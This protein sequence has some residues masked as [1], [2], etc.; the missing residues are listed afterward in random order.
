M[1]FFN[2]CN[3]FDHAKGYGIPDAFFDL[4][5]TGFQATQATQRFP[6]ALYRQGMASTHASS[7]A[8]TD[9]IAEVEQLFDLHPAS[10]QW[11]AQCLEL[12]RAAAAHVEEL[13]NT[14]R[15]SRASD[16]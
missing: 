4:A 14:I 11:H 5:T 7:E 10:R 9:I 2:N 3:T 12:L 8:L 6:S 1:F 16:P 13:K 15:T